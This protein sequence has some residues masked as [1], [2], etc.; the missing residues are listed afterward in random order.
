MQFF[1]DFFAQ[2]FYIFSKQLFA[3]Q[4]LIKHRKHPFDSKIKFFILKASKNSK[5]PY[6]DC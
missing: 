6:N 3:K 2:C 5:F 1:S 4:A